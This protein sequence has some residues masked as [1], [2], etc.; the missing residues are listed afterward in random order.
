M[1]STLRRLRL[2]RAP[3]PP[4]PPPSPFLGRLVYPTGHG[5]RSIIVECLRTDDG[6][7]V[8]LPAFNEAGNYL[9]DTPVSLTAVDADTTDPDTVVRGLS[10]LV[11]ARDIDGHA[12]ELLER[13]PGGP[14]SHYFHIAPAANRQLWLRPR[15]HRP[16]Q[17]HDP[18][19]LVAYSAGEEEHRD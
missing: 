10:R 12:A 5:P 13:W 17:L 2:H 14:A 8:H 16:I 15:R 19:R 1:T 7:T 6:Y 9:A 18:A 4:P 3:G 11:A